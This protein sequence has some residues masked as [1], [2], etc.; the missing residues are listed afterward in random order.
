MGERENTLLIDS[1]VHVWTDGSPPFTHN[2]GMTTSRPDYPGYVE[3]LIAFMDKNGIDRTVLIQCMYHGYDNSYMCDCISRFPNR[4]HGVAL[5]DPQKP[6][7]ARELEGLNKEQGVQGM[8]LYPIKDKDASWQSSEEQNALWETAQG[9]GVPF[10]WFGR[11]DQIPQLEPM[12]R[13]FPEVSIIIDHLGEPVLPEGIDG[14]FG[15]LL[16]LSKY[17]GVYVKATRI[18][19]IS[20]QDFPHG[21][22]HPWIRAVYEAFGAKRMLGCTGFPENPQRGDA[23][24]FRAVE[25]MDFLSAEDKE[26]ILGRTAESLYGR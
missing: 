26:W 5:I 24:G 13:R 18:D 6:D 17:P 9:L 3:D 16:A 19:G 8:R 4:L 22:L 25:A 11:C 21:D 20:E 1:H 2:D 12:L 23:I 14:S 15:N 7:A 10:T